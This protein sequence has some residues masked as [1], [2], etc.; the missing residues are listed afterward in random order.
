MNRSNIIRI[1]K[2]KGQI[3]EGIKNNIFK[4]E[5]IEAIARQ[6]NIICDMCIYIDRDGKKCAMPGT[7][8]CCSECGCSLRFKLRSLSSECPKNYWGAELT[9]EEEDALQGS[10][11]K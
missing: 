9:E 8:P 5:D 6:R 1:W 11:N 7:Q 4:T 2:S 10:I 3:L